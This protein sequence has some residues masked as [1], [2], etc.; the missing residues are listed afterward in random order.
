MTI[1]TSFLPLDLARSP[2]R[3]RNHNFSISRLQWP[4]PAEMINHAWGTRIHSIRI[5]ERTHL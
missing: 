4:H 2:H 3:P 1:A 5:V